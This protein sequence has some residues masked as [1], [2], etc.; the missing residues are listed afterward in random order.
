MH[1]D[2]STS[3]KLKFQNLL[4][5]YDMLNIWTHSN[6]PPQWPKCCGQE[7]DRKFDL[8]A[9]PN[10][11]KK[12]WATKVD[13]HQT[14]LCFFLRKK[15]NRWLKTH[16]VHRLAV[17]I[18]PLPVSF[19]VP[20]PVPLTVAVPLS[21]PFPVIVLVSVAAAGLMTSAFFSGATMVSLSGTLSSEGNDACSK[22]GATGNFWHSTK[23]KSLPGGWAIAFGLY[24]VETILQRTDEHFTAVV[25]WHFGLFYQTDCCHQGFYGTA[26]V[27]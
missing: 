2:I 1:F 9:E 20:V 17:A 27:S 5:W 6:V 26:V 23:K 24:P 10:F 7:S 4:N 15:Q 21:A 14:Q 11:S 3:L 18:F 19:T 8:F 16:L 12:R 22:A 13:F 25:C